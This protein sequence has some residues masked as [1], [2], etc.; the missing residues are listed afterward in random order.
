M[1]PHNL[2]KMRAYALISVGLSC[3]FSLGA[4]AEDFPNPGNYGRYGGGGYVGGGFSPAP[5]R[6]GHADEDHSWSSQK[7]M[8]DQVLSPA[9]R[10]VR[11]EM[12]S[13]ADTAKDLIEVALKFGKDRVT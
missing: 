3:L 10:R 9:L 11:F 5:A 4:Q 12:P 7:P 1:F 8:N 6:P 13:K 2:V